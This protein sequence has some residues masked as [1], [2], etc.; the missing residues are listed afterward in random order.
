[1]TDINEEAEKTL[2]KAQIRKLRENDE[3]GQ[4]VK[5]AMKQIEKPEDLLGRDGLLKELTR[6][7][8]EAAL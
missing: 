5:R 3:L 1:M 4:M 7:F 8:V 6:R 2:T